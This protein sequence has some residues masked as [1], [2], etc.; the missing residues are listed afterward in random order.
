MALSILGFFLLI[1]F[2]YLGSQENLS[3]LSPRDII[4]YSLVMVWILSVIAVCVCM[5]ANK[6]LR[7]FEKLS[8]FS[9]T[10][11][12]IYMTVFSLLLN[13]LETKEIIESGIDIICFV[14]FFIMIVAVYLV[15]DDF[16]LS[17]QGEKESPCSKPS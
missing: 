8:L 5:L 17:D 9:F 12:C 16:F 15:V 11:M 3:A 13:A 10:L 2:F 1:G 6:K 7:L 4:L 14:Y